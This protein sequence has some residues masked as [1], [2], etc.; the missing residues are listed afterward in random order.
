MIRKRFVPQAACHFRGIL[1]QPNPA[2]FSRI[3]ENELRTICK[4]DHEAVMFFASVNPQGFYTDI[5]AHAQVNEQPETAEL[6]DQEFSTPAD[7]NYCLPPEG[8][9]QL[10]KAWGSRGCEAKIVPLTKQ[11]VRLSPDGFGWNLN[12][13][14][15][16]QPGY[17]ASAQWFQLPGVQARVY[18]VILLS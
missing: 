11:P 18:P 13:Q 4:P 12:F 15:A 14:T 8:A 1:H 6:D 17:A 3:V 7:R 2:K 10:L 9:V 16:R 5:P